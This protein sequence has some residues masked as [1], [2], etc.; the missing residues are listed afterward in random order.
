[1]KT[2]KFRHNLVK[3]ILDGRKTVTWRLFDD[4]DLNVGDKLEFIDWDNGEKFAEAEIIAIREKALGDIEEADY[5]GHERYENQEEMLQNYKK[6]Y[7]DRVTQDTTIK[8]I[9]FELK[10]KTTKE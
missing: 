2:L 1:M 10:D 9:N 5:K 3:E 4:K 8:I 7:G 6:Y